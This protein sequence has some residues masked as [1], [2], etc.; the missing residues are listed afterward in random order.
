[1]N[2]SLNSEPVLRFK[3]PSLKYFSESPPKIKIKRISCLNVF[4]KIFK[5]AYFNNLNIN[6]TESVI[7]EYP[8]K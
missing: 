4:L 2:L 6:L 1:M 7:L 3:F 8:G 5:N